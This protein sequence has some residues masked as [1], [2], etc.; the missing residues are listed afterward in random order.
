MCEDDNGDTDVCFCSQAPRTHLRNPRHT[1]LR[2]AIAGDTI[3]LWPPR[4]RWPNTFIHTHAHA[5]KRTPACVF[6]GAP[7]GQINYATL[8]VSRML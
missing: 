5:R 2:Y 7:E 8:S 3:V 1:L 6:H 4:H